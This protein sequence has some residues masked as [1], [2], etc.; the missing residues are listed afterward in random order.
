MNSID[1]IIEELKISNC[2]FVPSIINEINTF[3]IHKLSDINNI[4]KN[5]FDKYYLLGNLVNLGWKLEN[6]ISSN[7]TILLLQLNFFS[8]LFKPIINRIKDV[9]IEINLELVNEYKEQIY[10]LIMSNLN[11]YAVHKKNIKFIQINCFCKNINHS[12]N[13]E[14]SFD[15]FG[16]GIKI[17]NLHF[18]DIFKDLIVETNLPIQNNDPKDKKSDLFWK[19][20][21][22]K[23][24]SDIYCEIH[25]QNISSTIFNKHL[26]CILND[27]NVLD[28][29][30]ESFKII[31]KNP[32]PESFQLTHTLNN[33]VF[34]Q[35][36]SM[37]KPIEK[38][39][40][41]IISNSI[42]IE[43]DLFTIPIDCVNNSIVMTNHNNEV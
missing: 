15:D 7:N 19:A 24:Y 26:D 12:I 33:N 4:Y 16:I 31:Q 20:I 2:Y 32:N 23:N 41:K 38:Q 14:I 18:K 9:C 3:V 28:D 25:K 17:T 43:D 13:K 8:G 29:D 27:N 34:N 36:I 1:N 37:I 42:I 11:K 22:Y 40:P 10:N 39:L 35:N 21:E 30:I 6:I 5:D